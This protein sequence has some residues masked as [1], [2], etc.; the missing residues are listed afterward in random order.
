MALGQRHRGV[1][2]PFHR[3][4]KHELKPLLN[5]RGEGGPALGRFCTGALEQGFI[6]ADCGSHVSEHTMDMSI[7]LVEN[8]VQEVPS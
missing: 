6:Q 1:F 2:G 5:E 4:P 7:C 3:P 8:G